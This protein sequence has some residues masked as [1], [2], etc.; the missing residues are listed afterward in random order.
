MSAFND[1]PDFGRALARLA[2]EHFREVSN[3]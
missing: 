2:A 3:D 1:D